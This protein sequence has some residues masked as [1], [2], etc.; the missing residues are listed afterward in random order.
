MAKRR[1]KL[2]FRIPPYVPPRLDWRERIH[3]AA[4]A[5]MLKRSVTIHDD[6]RLDVEMVFY[7]DRR[8]I[9]F[10]DI[11]NRIK[12]VLDALQGRIGG[13]KA[14]R[15]YPALIPNDR[16]VF[17]VT[18]IKKTPPPQSHGRGH[19]TISRLAGDDRGAPLAHES[20]G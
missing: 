10:H 3:G 8:A 18:A 17:R 9:E 7:L 2:H 4:L 16:Q 12:D 6:D 11:D 19:V 5:E 1:L 15:R 13:P 14:V 20:G